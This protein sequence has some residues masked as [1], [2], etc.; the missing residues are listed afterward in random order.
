MTNNHVIADAVDVEV[1]LADRRQYKGE[2]WPRSETDVA[3]VNS[4]DH[5]PTVTWGFE[6]AR[7]RANLCCDREPAWV[8]SQCD[9]WHSVPS[10][11]DGPVSPTSKISFKLMPP[12]NQALRRAW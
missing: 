2:W 1:I 5:L 4:G 10:S 3:V 12:S 7:R 8:E 9:V 11:P 6:Y